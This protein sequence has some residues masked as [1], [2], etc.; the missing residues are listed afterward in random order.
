MALGF[1]SLLPCTLLATLA[2]AAPQAQVPV[3]P[4]SDPVLERA[5]SRVYPSLVQIH[6]LS[7]YSEGGRERKFQA[8][9]SG[10]IIS[11]D[12]YVI[13][14]HHVVGKATSIRVILPT[15]E[16]LDATL[17]GTDPLADIAIIKL[18]LSQRA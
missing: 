1:R 2:V 10:A 8:S 11:A 5:I 16:E 4:H 18:D 13:T 14:N 17:L 6:V 15:F 7:A 12:G 3:L 9:G